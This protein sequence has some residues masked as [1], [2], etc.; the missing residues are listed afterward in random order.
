LWTP[1]FGLSANDIANPVAKFNEP[2]NGIRYILQAYNDAGCVDTASINIKVFNTGPSVF[3][4][5][6]FSP[7]NDGLNDILRPI[8]VGIKQMDFFSI[9]NRWGQLVFTTKINGKGWDGTING[10]YQSPGTYVWMVKAVDY[11]NNPYLQ[12]GTVVLVK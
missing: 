4:P 9:F 7:N 1:S 11:N 3:I 5:T 12:K 8:A 2:S 10:T 6:A